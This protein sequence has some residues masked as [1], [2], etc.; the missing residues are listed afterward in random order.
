MRA[1]L[2]DA[3]G[4]PLRLGELPDPSTEAGQWLLRVHYCGLNPVD[5]K[6]AAGG[7]PAWQWPHVLGLDVVGEVVAT[8]ADA[9][10]APNGLIAAHLDL[11]RRGGL[12]EY[13]TLTPGVTAELPGGLDPVAAATLPCPGL[14]AWQG[15]SRIAD[16]LGR[17]GNSR[18]ALVLGGGGPVGSLAVQLLMQRG[19][20]LA[21]TCGADDADR[22][23]ELGAQ[24]TADYHDPQALP[25][26]VDAAGGR[27]ACIV[28][29][30][31]FEAAEAA[32][33][34]LEFAGALASIT[35]RPI[36]GQ[37]PAFTL[38]PTLVEVSL[39]AIHS[40]GSPAQ[41]A[42]LGVVMHE[43]LIALAHGGLIAPPATLVPMSAA[44]T[45][46]TG[47]S[48]GVGGKFVVAVADAGD[49]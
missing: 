41:R 15:V 20:R 49:R 4:S 38:S 11:S 46:L 48:E 27:F 31:N 35:G 24:W 25:A 39:G 5:W 12:A 7:H 43:Q 45:T 32:A 29:A 10:P 34:F 21:A 22:V 44:A 26:L 47:M 28:N 40:Y 2:L 18:R 33:P 13:V 19:A 3:P 30:A 8:G 9:P 17:D 14:T 42:A 1:W 16:T 36:A 23:R 37:V 6:L